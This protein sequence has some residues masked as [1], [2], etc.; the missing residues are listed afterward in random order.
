MKKT[1]LSELMRQRGYTQEMIATEL[2]ITK[3]AVNLTISS[4]NPRLESLERI[5][6]LLKVPLFELFV[7]PDDLVRAEGPTVPIEC[8]HCGATLDA[9][10]PVSVRPQD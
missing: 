9:V 6:R 8:P 4:A 5:A 3:Q 2:G 1:R 7:N 10:L